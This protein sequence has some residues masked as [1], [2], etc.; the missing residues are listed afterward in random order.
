MADPLLVEE[1]VVVTEAAP[2]VHVIIVQEGES[3]EPTPPSENLLIVQAD[4]EVTVVE[5]QPD[6]EP[7]IIES[8]AIGP[9]GPPGEPGPGVEDAIYSVSPPGG[10]RITNIRLDA[11]KKIVITYVDEPVI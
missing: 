5:V 6:V 4:P 9:Q 2:E 7:N 3:I 1:H 10:Y 11:S 8:I